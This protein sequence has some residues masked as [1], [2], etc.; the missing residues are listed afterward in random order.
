MCLIGAEWLPNGPGGLN[1]YFH[2]LVYA[3]SRNGWGATGVVTYL[4]PGQAGPTRLVPLAAEGASLLAKWKGAQR[5]ARGLAKEEVAL[6]NPHFALYAYPFLRTMT[7]TV[8]IV[9]NF[10]GPWADE[11]LA[12]RTGPRWRVQAALARAIERRVYRRA[13]R[14]ITLS[15]AFAAILGERYGISRDRIRVV[16]GGV[17]LSGY[18]GVCKEGR[19]DYR[20]QLGWPP[21]DFVV[22]TVRRLARRM[23]LDR[24]IEATRILVA[25]YPKVRVMVVGKGEI[26]SELRRLIS[27]HGLE[28]HVVLMGYLPDSLLPLAYAAADITVV[29]SIALE[30]FGLVT[31]ESL[32]AGTPVIG[33]A[34]GGTPEVLG[35]ISPELIVETT[36]PD[37]IADKLRA[38]LTGRLVLPDARQCVA[39][40][41]RFGWEVVWPNIQRVWYEA[42]ADDGMTMKPNPSDG[43][44]A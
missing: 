43:I 6:V 10:H 17:D 20:R 35:G 7:N 30:G 39:Y 29:P 41:T 44:H 32:A 13:H 19:M 3:A 34:V 4:R 42:M 12:E 5:V 18:Q 27:A 38:A 25:E 11:I 24:L 23:G 26:E 33:T 22:L 9:V 40:A 16:P 28:H 21:D 14:L 15:A 8:P 36:D 2:G 31:V 37:G 1:R